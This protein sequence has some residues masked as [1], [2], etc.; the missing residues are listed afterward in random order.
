MRV[1]QTI[2]SNIASPTRRTHLVSLFEAEAKV[3][4]LEALV[5]G[6]PENVAWLEV[7]VDVTF[8]VQEGESLQYVPGTVL[9][10]PHRVA[11]LGSAEETSRC[12]RSLESAAQLYSIVFIIPK[13]R[14]F[15]SKTSV[16]R[17]L[18]A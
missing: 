13:F 7:G 5:V 2:N 12:T 11:L 4:E 1:K 9:D 3:D 6:A 10:E 17:P 14:S 8:P 15:N 18:K 16:E